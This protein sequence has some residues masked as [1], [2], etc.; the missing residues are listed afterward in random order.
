[1]SREI[2][3]GDVAGVKGILAK[4]IPGADGELLAVKTCLYTNSPDGHFIVDFHP[5][6]EGVMVACGF[7]GHGFKFASVMGE[8]LAAGIVTGK[9]RGE[10][11]FLGVGRFAGG[12]R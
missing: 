5:E 1:M 10:M 4:H 9:M 2:T 8:E 7:S 12:G 3:A 6:V 11:G